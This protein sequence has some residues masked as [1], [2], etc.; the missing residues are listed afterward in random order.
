MALYERIM[1]EE[2]AKGLESSGFEMLEDTE[3]EEVS[4][5]YVCANVARRCFEVIDDKTGE[6]LFSGF[7]DPLAARESAASWGQSTEVISPDY[8]EELRQK[9]ASSNN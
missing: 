2:G 3:L 5:G 9:N 8:L 4:G 6:V 7:T 1:S